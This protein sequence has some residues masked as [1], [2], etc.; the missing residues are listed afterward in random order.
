MPNRARAVWAFSMV[1]PLI[2]VTVPAMFWL[3]LPTNYGFELSA[4]EANHWLPTIWLLALWLAVALAIRTDLRNRGIDGHGGYAALQV[5]IGVFF[6][7][8]AFFVRALDWS[9][10]HDV[11]NVNRGDYHLVIREES[12]GATC[13]A[14][15]SLRQEWTLVPGLLRVRYLGYWSHAGRG[16]IVLR[17]SG[18]RIDSF[19]V[20]IAEWG[21]RRPV[22]TDTMVVVAHSPW[23]PGGTTGR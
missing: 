12:C 22:A 2:L 16:A 9:G 6:V 11:Q 17:H 7:G 21:K 4:P 19:A 10:A 23:D 1:F 14:D 15:L 8:I 5:L 3:R 18:S 20:H 13:D